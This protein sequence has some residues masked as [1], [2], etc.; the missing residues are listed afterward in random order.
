MIS[1]GGYLQVKFACIKKKALTNKEIEIFDLCE[2]DK[3]ELLTG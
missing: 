2:V 1:S 3:K